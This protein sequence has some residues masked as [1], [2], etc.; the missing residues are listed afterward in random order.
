MVP[1][2][3]QV[4]DGVGEV[5]DHGWWECLYGRGGV[6]WSKQ[7]LRALICEWSATNGE[8]CHYFLIGYESK[9]HTY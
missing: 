1:T 4:L 5:R 6:D 9:E 3:A 2:I 8:V 7:G